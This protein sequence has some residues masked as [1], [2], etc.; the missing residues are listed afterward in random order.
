MFKFGKSKKETKEVY[1]SEDF[2][3]ILDKIQELNNEDT[4]SRNNWKLR[5]QWINNYIDLTREQIIL[6]QK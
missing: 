1:Q 3:L 6:A 2:L 4:P 5:Q